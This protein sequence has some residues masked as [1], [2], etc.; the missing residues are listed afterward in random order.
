MVEH[1]RNRNLRGTLLSNAYRCRLRVAYFM[2]SLFVSRQLKE[3][4]PL[5]GHY[6]AAVANRHLVAYIQY[7]YDS[8]SLPGP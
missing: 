7:L 3:T 5:K 1:A 4:I 2:F 6:S 8:Q